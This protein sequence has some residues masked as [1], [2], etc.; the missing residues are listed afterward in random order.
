MGLPGMMISLPALHRSQKG[1]GYAALRRQLEH[2]GG[3]GLYDAELVL[4][5]EEGLC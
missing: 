5:G 1:T 3:L 4:M 2:D